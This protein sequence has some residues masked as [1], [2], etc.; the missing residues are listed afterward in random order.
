MA[1]RI[2]KGDTVYVISGKDKGKTG[3]VLRVYV[4]DDRVL[5][6]GVNMV[7]KHRKPNQRQP[8]GERSQREAPIHASKVMPVDP[9]T[10]K[11]S[12]VRFEEKD[13]KKVRVLK[14]GATLA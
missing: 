4:Q 12:R 5:V 7:T 14:S 13:G 9:S 8:E 2:K 11:G 6:Q 3:A 1:A 10:G